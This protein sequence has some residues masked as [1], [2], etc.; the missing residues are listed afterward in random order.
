MYYIIPSL[1]NTFSLQKRKIN[2]LFIPFLL[3]TF[4]LIQ[5]SAYS[6]VTCNDITISGANSSIVASSVSG[7]GFQFK[8]QIDGS[9]YTTVYQEWSSN[10]NTHEVN[11]IPI[12]DYKIT[13]NGVRCANL[14]VTAGGN[15]TCSLSASVGNIQCSDNGTNSDTSD[16]TFTFDLT[17]SKSDGDVSGTWSTTV[18]GTSISGNYGQAESISGNLISSG[19]ITVS[20][21]DNSPSNC[22]TT[23]VTAQAPSPCS[24][25][26][27][28]PPTG[29]GVWS[30]TGTNIFYDS[31]IVG[32]NMNNTIY[33]PEYNLMVNGDI[34]AQ[35]VKVTLEGWADYVFDDD[36]YLRPLKE[37]ENFIK[38]NKHLPDVPSEE[39]VLEEGIFVGE[40]N[41]ILLQKIEELTLYIIDLEKRIEKNEENLLNSSKK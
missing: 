28:N 26:G 38:D 5:N 35:R 19:N 41:K 23:S 30:L 31:G 25:G 22:S 36:Y 10:L 16:D 24:N 32:I 15:G 13:V 6:Q 34:K 7:D 1:S 33:D 8:A 14:L 40:T 21:S 29:G 11:N 12:G 4:T 39:E 3:V 2:F 18:N 17:V 37:V 20:I 9:P 27:S